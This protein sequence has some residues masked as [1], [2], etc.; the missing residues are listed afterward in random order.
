VSGRRLQ[1]VA[2]T[3][4]EVGVSIAGTVDLVLMAPDLAHP[5]GLARRVDG[6]RDPGRSSAS[7]QLL[8]AVVCGDLG[9]SHRSMAEGC[10][11]GALG[12]I[13]VSDVLLSF[14]TSSG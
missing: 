9:L 6:D 10:R 11:S 3:S 2:S 7:P 5:V 12:C 14:S 4:Y 8:C 1:S 13:G